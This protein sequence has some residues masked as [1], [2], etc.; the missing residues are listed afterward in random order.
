LA[1]PKKGISFIRWSVPQ[2]IVKTI[3]IKPD[4]VPESK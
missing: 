4:P 3:P 1:A 2:T